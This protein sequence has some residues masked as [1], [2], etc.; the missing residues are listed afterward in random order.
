MRRRSTLARVVS[1]LPLRESEF[2]TVFVAVASRRYGRVLLL[3]SRHP[4]SVVNAFGEV[5]VG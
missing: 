2:E 3:K 1:D 5:T 4:Q